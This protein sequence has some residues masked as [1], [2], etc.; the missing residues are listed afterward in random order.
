M[1]KSLL[2]LL[3]LLLVGLTISGCTTTSDPG[4]LPTEQSGD[5][6]EPTLVPIQPAEVMEQ[7]SAPEAV[8][9]SLEEVDAVLEELSSPGLESLPADLGI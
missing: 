5:S 4:E 6:V 9:A 1:K 8:D 3:I 7:K 2:S